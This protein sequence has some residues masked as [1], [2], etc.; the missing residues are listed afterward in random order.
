MPSNI[1]SYESVNA[2]WF[3]QV[4]TT[5]VPSEQRAKIWFGENDDIDMLIKNQY[6]HHLTALASGKYSE[7]LSNPHGQLAAILVLDQFSRHI[8][9]GKPEAYAQDALALEICLN[10]LKQEADHQLSLIERV[11]YYFPLLH[12]EN[13]EHQFQSIRSYQLLSELALAETKAVF[14]SFLKFANHH[15]TVIENFGRFPQRNEFLDRI[16]T[17]DELGYLTEIQD[18]E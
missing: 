6:G 2:F 18:R 9:R 17:P 14:D 16:S 5:I 11:F 10:G 7:W 3:G 12:S 8:Y 1:Q 13:L 4:E 15:Y